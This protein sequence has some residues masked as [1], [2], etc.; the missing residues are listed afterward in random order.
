MLWP[1]RTAISS[2]ASRAFSTAVAISAASRGETISA[3]QSSYPRWLM[4]RPGFTWSEER[5]GDLS[6][7]MDDGFRRVDEDI[8]EMRT[9]LSALQ[10][11]M[12]QVAAGQTAAILATLVTVLITR[13]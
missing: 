6:R 11:T 13:A 1:P 10:R 5:L 9:E 7:R 4:E 3:V 12:I 2:P 8:R